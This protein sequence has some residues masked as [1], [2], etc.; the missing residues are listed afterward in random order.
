MTV[1]EL[2]PFGPQIW[3]SE[4]PV[5]AVAGFR[6]PTRMAVIRLT[7]GSLFIWSPIALTP[8]LKTEVEALGQV[9]HIVAPNTLHDLHL[10]AWKQAFPQARLHASPGLSDKRKDLDFDTD[11]GD[12][13]EHAWAGQIDQVVVRG[14]L[15]TTEVVFFH[16]ASATVL[17]TDLIQN[18][19]PGWFTGWR[20]VVARLDR[21]LGERPQVPQKFRV[22]FVN[23]SAARAALG[24]IMAW[25]AGNVLMAHGTPVIGNGADFIRQAFGWLRA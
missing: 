3:T 16:Q 25:P 10:K 4:G 6:Y 15:I 22:A 1:P 12:E 8:G 18:F 2:K 17:F 7:D 11:L 13:A 23:K 21:M 9:S 14:N 5:V 24:R 19:P 20:A